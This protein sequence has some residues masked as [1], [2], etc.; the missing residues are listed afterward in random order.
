[1][2]LKRKEFE[3]VGYLRLRRFFTHDFK[4]TPAIAGSRLN[5]MK[6]I[7]TNKNPAIADLPFKTNNFRLPTAVAVLWVQAY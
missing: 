3:S 6:T 7:E 4:Y 2:V 1:V 5:R